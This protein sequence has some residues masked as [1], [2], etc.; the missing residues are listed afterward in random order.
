MTY[1][2]M[3]SVKVSQDN[4]R[5]W[6]EGGGVKLTRE[7]ENWLEANVGHRQFRGLFHDEY[8]P[9]RDHWL[10]TATYHSF[11]KDNPTKIYFRNPRHALLFKLTFC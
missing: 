4:R 9:I 5:V 8:R 6:I 7:A 10:I 11:N 2:N 1:P 3:T